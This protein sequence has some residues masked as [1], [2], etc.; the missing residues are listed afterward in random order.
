MM[1]QGQMQ[2]QQ[3]TPQEPI[4]PQDG[5]QPVSDEQRQALLDMIEKVRTKLGDFNAINF[6]NKNKVETLRSELLKQVFEKLQI[7]GV[8]LSD[9][10]SVAA[11][12][13][14]LQQN[15]PELAAAFEKAM[16]VLL[17]GGFVN[18]QDPTA[19]MDLG[20]DPSNNMNNENQNE[21]ITQNIPQG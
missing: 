3:A 12:L 7:A 1:P 9:R 6:A 19:S 11:F 8:D 5:S 21:E 13:A 4:M 16:D 18:P 20:I 10:E 14:N 15:N 17:G 2:D